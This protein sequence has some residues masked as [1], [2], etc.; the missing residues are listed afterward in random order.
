MVY[1][2]KGPETYITCPHK[3]FVLIETHTWDTIVRCGTGSGAL[4][5]S[6]GV[7]GML[8]LGVVCVHFGFT[9]SE[10][11][12]NFEFNFFNKENT[13]IIMNNKTYVLDLFLW[14][15][16]CFQRGRSCIHS[17]CCSKGKNTRKVYIFI[18]LLEATEKNIWTNRLPSNSLY[19]H[20]Y[21]LVSILHL[22]A[23]RQ[24]QGSNLIQGY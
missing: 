21:Q 7:D 17:V 9:G 2:K 1:P 18:L 6:S 8:A 12:L 13:K 20:L 14:K 15:R 23:M 24:E 11:I 10:N 19:I 3:L 5:L 16:T 4:V 22:G